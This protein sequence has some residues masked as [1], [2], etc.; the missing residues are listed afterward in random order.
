MLDTFGDDPPMLVGVELASPN[1]SFHPVY[2]DEDDPIDTMAGLVAPDSWD[3][4]A[5]V[6]EA[7]DTF[8]RVSSGVVSHCI[9]RDGRSATELDEWCGR[10]RSLRTF[11]GRLHEACKEVL[12]PWV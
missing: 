5:V 7:F 6:V 3:L 12:I 2:L 1:V 4:L 9:D 11:N 10:R 8:G